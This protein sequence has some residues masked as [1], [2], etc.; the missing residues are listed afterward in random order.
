MATFW[1]SQS[2]STAVVIPPLLSGHQALGTL[3]LAS[4]YEYDEGKYSS[5]YKV[6]TDGE[7]VMIS[8]TSPVT[9][10]FQNIVIFLLKTRMQIYDEPLLSSQPP[11]NGH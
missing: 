10:L 3:S 1:P 4:F 7:P 2:S 9:R 8:N 11:L 6:T 5:R